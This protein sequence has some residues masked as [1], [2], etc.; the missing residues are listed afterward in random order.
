[1]LKVIKDK[2]ELD[3]IINSNKEVIILFYAGWCPFSRRFLPVFEKQANLKEAV[4]YQIELF[5]NFEVFNKYKI[6]VYPT[7]IY[8]KNKKIAERLDGYPG[9]G[10]TSDECETFITKYF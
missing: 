3:E 5:N 7:L 8:F 6:D 2:Q 10:L 9:A 1:M 4:F